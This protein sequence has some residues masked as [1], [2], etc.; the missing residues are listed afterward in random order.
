MSKFDA[1]LLGWIATNAAILALLVIQRASHLKHRIY[2]R[3]V[4]A[5]RPFRF[6]HDLVVAHHHQR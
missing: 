1:V 2:W 3:V 5:V 4:G 6:A